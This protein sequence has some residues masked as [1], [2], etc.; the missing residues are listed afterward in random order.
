MSLFPVKFPL[1]L[2]CLLYL[3]FKIIN[4]KSKI[5]LII[6]MAFCA[7]TYAQNMMTPELLWKLKR[8]SPIGLTDDKQNVVYSVTA[9][10]VETEQN[11]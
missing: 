6:A 10:D 11:H 4:M 8:I 5:L 9:F 3:D 1:L 7:Q 2:L